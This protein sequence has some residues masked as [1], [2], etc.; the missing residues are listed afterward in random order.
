L[1]AHLSG[2]DAFQHADT[3]FQL[4][5]HQTTF[6]DKPLTCTACHAQAGAGDF[7][8]TPNACTDCHTTAAPEFM[9][10][11]TQQ[12]GTNCAGCHDGAGNMQNFDHQRVFALDGAHAALDCAACHVDQVF[13]GTAQTCAGCHAEPPIHAG[14]FGTACAACHTTTA[15]VPAQLTQHTFPLDH[16]EQGDIACATCHTQTYTAYTCYGCHEHELQA[17]AAR[18]AKLNLSAESLLACAECHATGREQE[19]P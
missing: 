13:H 5:N 8:L 4:V 9:A 6:A 12:Y 18:H 3:S 19:G 2:L 7:S 1:P 14:I 10:G 15:W 11:H 17:T 16:G